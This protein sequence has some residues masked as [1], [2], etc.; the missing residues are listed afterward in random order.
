M[1]AIGPEE[2]EMKGNCNSWAYKIFVKASALKVVKFEPNNCLLPLC[3]SYHMINTFPGSLDR[4]VSLL[5]K[6][7]W[8][9]KA[10]SN[11]PFNSLHKFFLHP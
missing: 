11:L 1:F 4:I 10:Q 9:L 7:L 3:V 8:Y 6:L 5:F 2:A